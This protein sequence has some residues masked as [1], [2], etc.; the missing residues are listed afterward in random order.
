MSAKIQIYTS[1]YVIPIPGVPKETLIKVS[2]EPHRLEKNGHT[3]HTIPEQKQNVQVLHE[4]D[5]TWEQFSLIVLH[6]AD[7]ELEAQVL[8]KVLI[9]Y[10]SQGVLT[11][12]Q[13]AAG[14]TSRRKLHV[15]V[16]KSY[17]IDHKLSVL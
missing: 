3:D 6:A 2:A 8:N 15:A 14:N 16:S 12:I 11:Q 1:E 4:L 7:R 13:W 9:I 10:N 5:L 17:V